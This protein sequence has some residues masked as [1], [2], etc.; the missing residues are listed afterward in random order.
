MG[1]YRK[2]TGAIGGIDIYQCPHIESVIFPVYTNKTVSGNFRGPE[3]PQGFFGIQSM[4]D[5]VAYKM[6]MDPV[7]FILKNMTRMA[8][9]EVPFTNYTLEECIRRGADAFDWKTRWRRQ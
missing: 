5:E 1:G 9:D 8:R 2:N 4:M 6:N 7:E 3:F